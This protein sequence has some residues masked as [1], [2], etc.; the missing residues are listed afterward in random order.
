MR[1]EYLRFHFSPDSIAS[2]RASIEIHLEVSIER[3]FFIHSFSSIVW[4]YSADLRLSVMS[5]TLH[6]TIASCIRPISSRRSV[7]IEMIFW[8]TSCVL[9]ISDDFLSARCSDL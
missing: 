7:P 4:R 8:V 9:I 3:I 5:L 2:M 1:I 6:L